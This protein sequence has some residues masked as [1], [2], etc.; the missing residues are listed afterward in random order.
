MKTD[1]LCR[2]AHLARRPD[3]IRLILA[4]HTVLKDNIGEHVEDSIETM[5]N[6]ELH[7]SYMKL[8]ICEGEWLCKGAEYYPMFKDRDRDYTDTGFVSNADDSS[9]KLRSSPLF[10]VHSEAIRVVQLD[11]NQLKSVPIELFQLKNV[12]K[13]NIS[14]NK[15]TSLPSS[16]NLPSTGRSNIDSWTCPQLMELNI[17]KNELTHLPTCLWELPSLKR[18]ICSRNKLSSLLEGDELT[19]LSLDLEIIDLSHNSLTDM[20]PQFIFEFPSL[21]IL[22]LSNN[23]IRELPETLWSCETLQ[24][25]NLSDNQLESLPMC[26]PE[27][28]YRS[29][30][31]AQKPHQPVSVL[32]ADKVLVGRVA[33]KAPSFDRNASLFRRAPST[34]RAISTTQEHTG[35]SVMDTCDYSSLQKLNLTNNKIS[36]FPEALPCFAPNLIE[37]DISRNPLYEIDVQFIPASLKKLTAKAC[38]IIR[39][40]NVMTKKLQSQIVRN[41]R[42][43]ES[44]GSACQ[45]RSHNHL[46]SL[47]TI[48]L[49]HNKIPYMQ[50]IRQNPSANEFENFG[51]W[52]NTYDHKIAPGLD[53][54]YPSLEGLNLTGNCL[55]GK[56]NPNIGHQSHLKWIRLSK[57]KDL[58]AIPMEF[59]YLKNTK[60]LTEL[61]M[62]DLPNLVEPPVEYQ[63]VSLNHLLTYMRSKLKA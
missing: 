32:Q 53:L 15:I 17:S 37:L 34:I 2:L 18:F 7:W 16:V 26:E 23:K 61:G 22:N 36:M 45:H 51:K 29:S 3:L 8:P 9:N 10:T 59:A 4:Y 50:L 62:D 48:D 63:Q 57:N 52:E 35:S 25:L 24:D 56:F 31:H 58:T 27:L 13:I 21:R 38:E 28:I 42:H 11:N 30:F 1:W 6:L 39:I 12:Q 14:Y 5:N 20:V 60:Q 41:C 55:V 43:G 46:V 33:V 54:L 40:G 47:T 19:V 49:S 44:A